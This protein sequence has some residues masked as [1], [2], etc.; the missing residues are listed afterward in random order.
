MIQ[1]MKVHQSCWGLRRSIQYAL[2]IILSP[3]EWC[4]RPSYYSAPLLGTNNV[5]SAALQ[6][7][8]L[9]EVPDLSE[10]DKQLLV[11]AQLSLLTMMLLH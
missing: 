9:P 10:E 1:E 4:R 11:S 8:D 5:F 6:D 7:I 2:L 3:E